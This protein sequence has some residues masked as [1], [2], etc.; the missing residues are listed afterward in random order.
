MLTA[1]L[2]DWTGAFG[3]TY[4]ERNPPNIEPR[5]A[6]WE[7]IIWDKYGNLRVNPREILEVGANVGQNLIALK[8][9]LS[10]PA[11]GVEP[12]AKALD[13]L[14]AA[15]ITG[16]PGTAEALDFPADAFDLVFTSGVLVHIPPVGA[17]GGAR[18]PLWQACSE[19]ARVSKRWVVAIEYFSAQPR[20][21]IYRDRRGLLWARD[22]GQ[23]YI[24]EFG[25][26]PMACGFAWK[27]LTGLDNLTWWLLRKP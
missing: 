26:E 8:R 21:I 2:D 19:I 13:A 9:L 24:Q 6:L 16:Y 17:V 25:L 3:D 18:S 1:P 12:N 5:M 4:T 15:G 14:R 11:V 10:V 27:A 20:E 7:E 23:F 22:F